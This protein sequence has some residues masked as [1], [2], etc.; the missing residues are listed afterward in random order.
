MMAS[1]PKLE[2]NRLNLVF[3]ARVKMTLPLGDFDVE[4]AWNMAEERAAI[5][6]YDGGLKRQAAEKLAYRQHVLVAPVELGASR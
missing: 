6:E 3:A 2:W 1:K 5:M 4:L